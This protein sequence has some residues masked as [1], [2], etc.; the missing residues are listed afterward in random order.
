MVFRSGFQHRYSPVLDLVQDVAVQARGERF[1]LN[2]Q[3][4]L[5][6]SHPLFQSWHPNQ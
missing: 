5:L 3:D 1:H 6:V 2:A 4:S